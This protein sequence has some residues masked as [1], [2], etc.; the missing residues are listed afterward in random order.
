MSSRGD[1]CEIQL[2][3][4]GGVSRGH[5]VA[6]IVIDRNTPQHCLT[7]KDQVTRRLQLLINGNDAFHASI[8]MPPRYLYTADLSHHGAFRTEVGKPAN[9]RNDKEQRVYWV[10]MPNWQFGALMDNL[11]ASVSKKND[12]DVDFYYGAALCHL[13]CPLLFLELF[14]T[15]KVHQ[16]CTR[17]VYQALLN[18]GIIHP[19]AVKSCG[20]PI[21][22]YITPGMLE[23]IMQ[24]HPELFKQCSVE[25]MRNYHKVSEPM[26]VHHESEWVGGSSSNSIMPLSFSEEN[27]SN[28]SAAPVYYHHNNNNATTMTTEYEQSQSVHDSASTMERRSSKAYQVQLGMVTNLP[29][30]SEWNSSAV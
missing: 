1:F 15:S 27:G 12:Y 30:P 24:S 18:V 26:V 10:Q 16:T 9:M 2:D 23:R 17:M 11:D 4:F 22:R 28:K 20:I 6:F 25:D 8:Y 5:S 14:C 29:P 7:F 3:P 19:L 13:W 21:K